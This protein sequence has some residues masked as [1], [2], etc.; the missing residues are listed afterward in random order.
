MG[1]GMYLLSTASWTYHKHDG[2]NVLESAKPRYQHYLCAGATFGVPLATLLGRP[3]LPK[4]V[5]AINLS[6]GAAYER[7]LSN[8]PS[9]RYGNWRFTLGLTR[10]FTF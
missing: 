5:R 2:T 10:R 4:L 6:I 8:I 7:S 3:N 1:R 9:Y